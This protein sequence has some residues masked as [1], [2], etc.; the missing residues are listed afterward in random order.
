MMKLNHIP[1]GVIFQEHTRCPEFPQWGFWS[2]DRNIHF[3][4]YYY[5]TKFDDII[6]TLNIEYYSDE[7]SSSGHRASATWRIWNEANH[8]RR[9]PIDLRNNF[10]TWEDAYEYRDH[11][12]LNLPSILVLRALQ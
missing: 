11:G 7:T 4:D 2:R 9:L 1:V 12:M 3:H 8:T 5:L 10:M 6:A